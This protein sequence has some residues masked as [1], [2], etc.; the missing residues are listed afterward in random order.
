MVRHYGIVANIGMTAICNLQ[1]WRNA[2]LRV[3][4]ITSALGHEAKFL[5]K[6]SK[7]DAPRNVYVSQAKDIFSNLALEHWLYQNV[8]LSSERI[9]L[10]WWNDPCVVIGRH[11]NPFCE[12]NIKKMKENGVVLARRNS[13]G[14][15][16]YHDRGNLNLSFLAPR[17]LYNRRENL[18]IIC[19]ALYKNYGMNVSI[20]P[21]DDIFLDTFYKI[22]GTA[23]KLGATNSYHH[24][25]LL[26]DVD[27]STLNSIL[28]PED[29]GIISR[30]TASVP[31]MTKNL[32]EDTPTVNVEGIASA[33]AN[34]YLEVGSS[35]LNCGIQ[36]V[37]PTES[38]F[39]GIGAIIN[40]LKS[41]EWIYD[42]TPKFSISKVVPVPIE[43]GSR[44]GSSL[45]IFLSVEHGKI[46][47]TSDPLKSL[48]ILTKKL[49]NLG[50]VDSS[51][52]DECQLFCF[53]VLKSC[54]ANFCIV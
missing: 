35:S 12:V 27:T 3:A 48:D 39:P 8:D 6:K 19:D 40:E 38:W 43:F 53:E 28:T 24:C 41:I 50:E 34:T 31:S 10:L 18:K 49:Y 32:V 17:D 52:F 29:I 4:T 5:R 37:N 25:T 11:Q 14:G 2:S 51:H 54:I 20:N 16:V 22:S 46:V 45:N 13:G 30:A 33:V 36:S 44:L 42:K 9:L 47:E 21:R 26:V 7:R 23:S 1:I 15:T